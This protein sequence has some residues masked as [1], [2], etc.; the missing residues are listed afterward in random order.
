MTAI[1]PHVTA[2]FH[3]RLT[4]ERR[5]SVNTCDSYAYAFQMLL[6][7]ASKHLKTT[8]SKL[9]LEQIDRPAGGRLLAPPRSS[10]CKRCQFQKRAACGNQIVHAL[11]GVPS[12]VSVGA[13]P[14]CSCHSNE[15]R[16]FTSRAASFDRRDT[17]TPGCTPA[18]QLGRHP[19]PCD[20]ALVVS[21]PDCVCRNSSVFGWKTY[22]CIRIRP[23]SCEAKVA[24]SAACHFGSRLP[25]RCAPG[26]L[27]AASLKH[28]R[29]SSTQDE[30][31]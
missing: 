9:Q 4:L 17:G 31:P 24:G 23:L 28:L 8:P 22:P 15:K 26:W 18:R 5:A 3:Q 21:L 29:S 13:D 1:A 20:A 30:S 7:Y 14:A 12:A 11:H 16:R 25:R 2:F 6:G 10:M 19:G 27:F